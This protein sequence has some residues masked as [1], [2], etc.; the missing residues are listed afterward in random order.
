[1]TKYRNEASTRKE[2]IDQQL[3]RAGWKVSDPSQV[4]LELAVH[5]GVTKADTIREESSPARHEFIDYALLDSTGIPLAVVEAKREGRDAL[6]GKRQAE[7]YAR[8]I[9]AIHQRDPFIFLTNGHEI[10]FYEWG[11]APP[12]KV[13]GFFTRNDLERLRFQRENRT[14]IS[15]QVPKRSIVDRPYQ[16]EAVKRV[17]E[18][19]EQGKRKFLLVMA[20]GTGKTRTVIAL[21]DL[22]MR[23]NWVHRVLFLADRR[24]LV[25]QALGD[26][27][28]HMPNE[29]RARIESG[30]VDHTARIHVATYPSMVQVYQNLSPG[31][32]DLIVADESHRSIYNRYK[33]L[34]DY[35]DAYQLGLTATPTDYIDH[36]TFELFD[37]PDGLPTFNYAYETAVEEEYLA[38]YRVLEAQ[39]TFQIEGI[40]AGQLPPE[41]QRQLE[42]QGIELS[43]IDFEGSDLERRVTNTGTTH[44]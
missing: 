21:I 35:F 14:V 13:S 39:T 33:V 3:A 12:R 26:F 17:A 4:E 42:A 36:N 43:E 32:Y 29:T 34:F 22:L 9:K 41:I 10:W 24:E 44:A 28:E 38:Q 27:K 1:M 25:S 5:Y 30:Q 20:T 7:D 37:C 8:S 40:R 23:N 31:Y 6:A 16:I 19:L 15:N 2:L 18:G 11:Y